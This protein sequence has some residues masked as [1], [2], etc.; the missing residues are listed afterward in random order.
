MNHWRV[1]CGVSIVLS[2]LTVLLAA[3]EPGAAAGNQVTIVGRLVDATCFVVSS[4]DASDKDHAE[5][6]SACLASGM[7]AGLLPDDADAATGMLFLLTNPEPLSGQVGQTVKVAGPRYE[8][9]N[10]MDVQ[11]LWVR[12]GRRWREVRLDDERH[13]AD[14]QPL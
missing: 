10:A 14:E 8:H 7:P 4:G 1:V 5:C 12:N 13:K 3:D 6:G 9:F 11:R 2:V